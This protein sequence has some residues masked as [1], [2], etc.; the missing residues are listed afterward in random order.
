MGITLTAEDG[1]TLRIGEVVRVE[2]TI[3]ARHDGVGTVYCDIQLRQHSLPEWMVSAVLDFGAGA[4]LTESA[5]EVEGLL[6]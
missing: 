1:R 4:H 6:G 3:E 2:L 5:G